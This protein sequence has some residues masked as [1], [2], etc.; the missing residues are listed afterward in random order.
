MHPSSARVKLRQE[1]RVVGQGNQKSVP[2]PVGCQA[3]SDPGEHGQPF[4]E[5]AAPDPKRDLED[6]AC[7]LIL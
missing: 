7:F 3:E 1:T 2:D 5:E 6:R 4:G